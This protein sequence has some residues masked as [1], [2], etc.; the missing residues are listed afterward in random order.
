MYAF[1]SWFE[2]GSW[3]FISVTSSVRKSLAEIVD[4]SALVPL[5][6]VDALVPVVPIAPFVPLGP[7]TLPA[8]ADA[9]PLP[10]AEA[11]PLKAVP[12]AAW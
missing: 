8:L 12:A 11:D 10:K 9:P 7:A 6:P 4:E 1:G 3:F 5:E 2:V